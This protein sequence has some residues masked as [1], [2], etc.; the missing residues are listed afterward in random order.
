MGATATQ[1][2]ELPASPTNMLIN[3]AGLA[4]ALLSLL[5]IREYGNNFGINNAQ[6]IFILIIGYVLPIISLEFIFL[7]TYKNKSTG[8]NFIKKCEPNIARVAT[9][10]LGFILTL[11]ILAFIYWLFTEYRGA[12]YDRYYDML[13]IAVP[14]LL[15][16]S[17]PYFYI[18]DQYMAKPEDGFWQMGAIFLG[19]K[20]VDKAA[21]WQHMLGW[22][23]KGFFLPLMF[24]YFSDKMG[25]LRS[26]NPAEIFATYKHFWDFTY[27]IIFAVDLL[28]ATVG[29]ILT[30]RLFDAHIRTTEPTF[31]GWFVTLVCYQPLWSGLFGTYLAY[32]TGKPWGYWFAANS[33]SYMAWGTA[34][35]ILLG[36]YVWATI[37]FGIR[38]SNLTNRGILTNGPYRFCKHPAYISKNISWWLIS[39]PFMVV[40]TPSEALRHSMLLLGLNIIYLLRARTEER[41]LSKD[42]VYVQYGEYMNEHSVFAWVGRIFPMLKF[43][44]GQL[45]NT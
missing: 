30:I 34:I 24:T 26:F 19:L 5:L 28:I 13:K 38:F 4:G 14:I 29:Y 6:A 1:P 3:F 18:I 44:P 33:L 37:A 40:S 45:F 41:L 35:I 36:I 2:A 42:P 23:V 17:I 32:D 7:K 43:K 10:Y 11:L 12:F 25:Y 15:I 31:L 39:M 8:L 22:F 16:T 9:K 27:N 21:A 20:Q